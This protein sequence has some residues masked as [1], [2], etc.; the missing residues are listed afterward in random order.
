MLG[1]G[2][3]ST[4]REGGPRVTAGPPLAQPGSGLSPVRSWTNGIAAVAGVARALR[5][6]VERGEDAAARGDLGRRR[7][8]DQRLA[9]AARLRAPLARSAPL[10]AGLGRALAFAVEVGLRLAALRA[11]DE[12]HARRRELL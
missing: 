12:G 5:G 6:V 4:R 1:R 2:G 3:A 8:A 7:P 10:A 9:P 11:R